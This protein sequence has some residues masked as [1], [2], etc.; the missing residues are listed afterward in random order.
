[1]E[2]E[3]GDSHSSSTVASIFRNNNMYSGNDRLC[4]VSNGNSMSI[5]YFN[6]R[7]IVP[8]HDELCVVVEANN[9][10]I[11]CIVE[12]WLNADILDSVIAL[13]GYQVH[14][15]DRNW[16][17]GGILVYV[18]D[19]FVTSLHASPDNLELLTLS[20]CSGTN[21]VCIS[22]FYRPPNSPSEVFENLFF[23]LTVI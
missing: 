18:R 5:L 14:R 1:M 10:D 3:G 11:V 21:K 20:P 6:A 13:P 8:K 12:T 15:L 17:G 16:H 9:P 2:L 4:N 23:V 19:T 7:S 22:L